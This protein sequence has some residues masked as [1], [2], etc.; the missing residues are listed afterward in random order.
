[1]SFIRNK[2]GRLKPQ[3]AFQTA[4]AEAEQHQA[5]QKAAGDDK[6]AVMAEIQAQLSA[7]G[8]YTDSEANAA[9][10]ATGY[11]AQAQRMGMTAQELFK[12]RPLSIRGESLIDDGAFVQALKNSPPK[13]WV[14]AEDGQATADLWN[15][16]QDKAVFWTG[17]QSSI[18]N[19]L[20]EVAGYPHSL[21]KSAATHIRNEHGDPDTEKA[22]GQ[23][24]VTENDIAR[25]PEIIGSYDA[26]RTDLKTEDG[27]PM[28][29]YGKRFDDGVVLYLAAAS[30]KKKTCMQ[31]LCGSIPQQPMYR[32]S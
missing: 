17:I 24:A 20:P 5:Q 10:A 26:V 7:A 11:H 21:S 6:N 3:N 32:I 23:I 28:V 1:M 22:R 2:A 27:A 15:G 30:R 9:L 13:R 29:A 18:G 8:R 16:G 12:Q 4:F 25:I 19:V 14:H 31:S